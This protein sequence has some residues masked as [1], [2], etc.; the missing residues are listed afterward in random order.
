MNTYM[1]GFARMIGADAPASHRL[2]GIQCSDPGLL[3]RY[4]PY[5][6]V[7][8]SNAIAPKMMRRVAWAPGSHR[9]ASPAER[10][11]TELS[12]GQRQRVW[13]AM[14]SPKKLTFYCWT[15]RPP[16]STW[17]TSWSYSI[18]STSTNSAAN[19]TMIMVLHELELAAR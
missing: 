10:Q 7:F 12:G 6:G 17:H 13:I 9:H 19:L 4:L 8:F 2:E 3:H 18:Y 14:A 1:K 5:Q 11:V 15:S 16:T